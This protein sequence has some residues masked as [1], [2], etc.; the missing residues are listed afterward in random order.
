MTP[1]STCR[2]R[3]RRSTFEGADLKELPTAR[4]VNNLLQLTPAISSNYRTG[5]AFG[6]PGVCVGGIGVFCNPGLNGFN[7]GDTGQ[8]FL[9]N[10]IDPTGVSNTIMAQGR[11]MV[12]GAGRQRRRRP[13]HRRSDRRLHCR[14]RAAQEIN[15]QIS[16]ALGDSET[17][18]ASINIVPRTGGNR[19]AG[20]YNTTYTR[21]DVV[22]PQH[23]RIPERPGALSGGH[24]RSRHLGR[25]RRSDQARLAVVLRAGAHAGHPQAAGRRRLLAEPERREVRVQLSA[26]PRGAARRVQEHLAQCERAFHVAGHARNKFNIFWDEQD[27]CQDPCLGVVSV[28][29]SPESW[30]SP[31]TKPNRLQQVSW[32][33]PISNR[34]L[35]EAGLSVTRQN[36][37]TT[38]HRQYTNPI[39]IPRVAEFGD[40]A[41]MDATA[42][43]VNQFAG[44]ALFQLT[45]GS[46]NYA[47]G[48]ALAPRLA[49][50]RQLPLA[51]VGLVRQRLASREVRLRRRL[52][53]AAPDQQGQRPA[54]VRT[55]TSGR[56]RPACSPNSCG[57]TSLQFPE[58]PNNLSRRPVPNTLEYNTGI[59]TLHDHV[60]Y[61]A[62]YAQDQWTFKRFTLSGALRYDHATS[63]YGETCIGPD[64]YV[65]RQ[66]DGS[67]WYC[68]PEGDGV[69]FND[70]TPRW[71]ASWDV[72]GTG[73]TAVKWNMGRFLTA[74]SI[75]GIY[76]GSQ[77]GAPHGQPAAAQLERR[78]R[79][80]PCGLRPDELHAQRRVRR[81]RE[82]T[83]CWR[84]QHTAH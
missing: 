11:V 32:T 9:V 52:L 49:T 20:D 6:Q 8:G 65:P 83:G 42:P 37:N 70:I 72:F 71:G 51:R 14:H 78:E 26:R 43:R 68:V 47:I 62:L 41:G 10:G 5:Q 55:T 61:G 67:N 35:L 59:G 66:F 17:G 33:N 4:N 46:L 73:K 1:A 84:R 21:D 54:A 82:R 30:F 29:T 24:L 12:D 40:T 63:G 39:D 22:R 34:I 44:G 48:A 64:L 7:V 13:A 15:V 3:V 60:M 45:S 77:P 81:V 79:Q 75:T 28:Y 23:Q 19:Y 16:G 50:D 38:E 36:Y 2:T 58:D 53:H 18:G 25:L 80:P 31:Q 76:S 57:N 74:A 27:F 69:N 56:E